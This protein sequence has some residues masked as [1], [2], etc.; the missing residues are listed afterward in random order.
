M[1]ELLLH[2]GSRGREENLAAVADW[3]RRRHD[4]LYILLCTGAECVPPRCTILFEKYR[5]IREK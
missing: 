4:G 1:L 3:Y 2:S 5:K